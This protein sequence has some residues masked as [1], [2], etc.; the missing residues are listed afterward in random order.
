MYCLVL[1][2]FVFYFFL[3]IGDR[4]FIK[5]W[6]VGSDGGLLWWGEN[7]KEEGVRVGVWGCGMFIYEVINRVNG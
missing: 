7:K 5:V 6:L 3:I 1:L 2:G 4:V